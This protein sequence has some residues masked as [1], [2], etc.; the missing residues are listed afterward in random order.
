MLP[1]DRQGRSTGDAYVQFSTPDLCEKALLKHK[2]RIGHRYIEIFKSS[3]NE[4]YGQMNPSRIRPLMASGGMGGGMNRP[5][6]YDRAGRFGMGGGGG[7]GGMGMGGGG[8][9]MGYGMGR[10]GR[11]VKGFFEDEYDDF[12]GGYGS[13]MG[14][15]GRGRRGM[16]SMGGG[17]MRPSRGGGSGGMGLGS[18]GAMSRQRGATPGSHYVSKTGHSVHM[19]GLPFQALDTDIAEFFSPLNIKPVSVEVEYGPNGRPTGEANVDFATHQEAVEAMK[20]HKKNMQHRYIELFLNSTQTGKTNYGSGGGFG[21]S[22]SGS[23]GGFGDGGFSN[24][25]GFGGN[26]YEGGYGDGMGPGGMMGSG[27]G[28]GGMGGGMGSGMSSGYG[29]GGM[30]GGM[31]MGNPNYTAF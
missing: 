2:E 25:S 23:G 20:N 10:G 16:G 24:G 6:P 12:G 1:E 19:R 27:G 17:S 8:M 7:G 3:L 18:L 14:F 21:G 31:G 4:A 15:G 30:G 28:S 9:G 5:G 13:G 29:S 22:G 11:N 26:G